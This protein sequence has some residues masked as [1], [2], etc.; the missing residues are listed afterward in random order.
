[1]RNQYEMHSMESVFKKTHVRVSTAMSDAIFAA[2]S[3][4][5]RLGPSF[6]WCVALLVDPWLAHRRGAHER[7]LLKQAL[8]PTF[9]WIA[10]AGEP[11]DEAGWASTLARMRDFAERLRAHAALTVRV[12]AE[13]NLAASLRAERRALRAFSARALL[14]RSD[15]RW[16]DMTAIDAPSEDNA[17]GLLPK[18]NAKRVAFAGEWNERRLAP[19]PAPGAPLTAEQIEA[20]LR[21]SP[22]G[23]PF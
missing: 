7:E 18:S 1:M 23:T 15:R 12:D 6:G 4:V 10:I 13:P 19:P 21:A 11:S 8:G 9:Q 16:Y 17:V 5:T 2:A 3:D 22:H 20:A 14:T